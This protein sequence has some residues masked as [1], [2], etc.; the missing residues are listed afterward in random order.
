MAQPMGQ[1]SLHSFAKAQTYDYELRMMIASG[2]IADA[3]VLLGNSTR[4]SFEKSVVY[5]VCETCRRSGYLSNIVPLLQSINFSYRC[6][7]DDVMPLLKQCV[8]E[9]KI[10]FLQTLVDYLV[11]S[12]G[13]SMTAKAFSILLKGYGVA[14]WEKSIDDVLINMAKRE[15]AMDIVLLNSAMDAYI[16]CGNINKAVQLFR[17]IARNAQVQSIFESSLPSTSSTSST[18]PSQSSSNRLSFES[19]ITYVKKLSS[20]I[21]PDARSFNIVLKVW[22]GGTKPEDLEVSFKLL[23]AMAAEHLQPTSV[24]ISTLIMSCLRANDVKRAMGLLQDYAALASVEAFTSIIAKSAQDGKIDFSLSTLQM[25][26]HQGIQPNYITWNCIMGAC[27]GSKDLVRAKELLV[28]ADGGST[29]ILP[30]NSVV[31]SHQDRLSLYNAYVV[32]CFKRFGEESRETHFLLEGLYTLMLM[33]KRR[34]PLETATYNAFMKSLIELSSAKEAVWLLKIM[35]AESGRGLAFD[36]Y[37]YSALFTALGRLGYIDE[38]MSAFTMLRQEAVVNTYILNSL[39]SACVRQNRIGLALSIVQSELTENGA[40]SSRLLDKASLC[41]VLSALQKVTTW[42]VDGKAS[43]EIAALDSDRLSYAVNVR[44]AVDRD[45][46]VVSLRQKINQLIAETSDDKSALLSPSLQ[47][48]YELVFS[49]I[50]RPLQ[51]Q[52]ST[53]I[54]TPP[55]MH[56]LFELD[57]G[58]KLDKELLSLYR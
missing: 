55:D 40:S 49:N 48:L 3:R 27:V 23:D 35:T 13:L 52:P 34:I 25:M 26:I 39:L 37:T 24:T 43:E 11:Q 7:E 10:H 6:A 32:A 36:D 4:A 18:S 33:N 54:T 41:I 58:F 57:K 21:K 5:I 9:K 56:L 22:Q 30:N 51:Y 29:K 12:R 53:N 17:A 31:V 45:P 28:L 38:A 16:K 19:I 14:R 47:R 8:D 1:S 44:R 50:Q 46:R 42:E 15:V 20:F 2:K